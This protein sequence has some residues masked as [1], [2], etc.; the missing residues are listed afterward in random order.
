VTDRMQGNVDHVNSDF[1]QKMM[2]L[3]C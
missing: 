1:I 3:L 2:S